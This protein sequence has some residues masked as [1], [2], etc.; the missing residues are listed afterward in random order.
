MGELKGEEKISYDARW[1]IFVSG[2]HAVARVGDA[3]GERI[4]QVFK[5]D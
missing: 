2:P 1:I 3:I 5:L 4:K